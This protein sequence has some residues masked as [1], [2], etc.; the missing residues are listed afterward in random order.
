VHAAADL[1]TPAEVATALGVSRQWVCKMIDSG[2]LAHV[3][4][5]EVRE[6]AGRWGR[7][8]RVYHLR[9]VPRAAVDAELER[10]GRCET[11]RAKRDD[12]KAE[13]RKSRA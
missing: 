10:R 6:V 3:D 13:L 12:A 9:R 8:Q 4:I 2:A 1:L 5:A 11:A 7:Y